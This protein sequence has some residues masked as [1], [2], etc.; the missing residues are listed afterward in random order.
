MDLFR[1]MYLPDNARWTDPDASPLLAD[2]L[3]DLPPAFVQVAG[4]D[5][6][7]DEGLAYVERLRDAGVPVQVT[8][9]PT[10]IHGFLRM[11]RIVNVAQVGLDDVAA[12]LR[13][14]FRV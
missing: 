2:D 5:P 4:Y 13:R 12:A 8:E 11:G 1:G 10:M 9:Y 14:A 6:L 3:A 7:R